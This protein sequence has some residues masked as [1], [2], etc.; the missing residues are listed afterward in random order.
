[1]AMG[2]VIPFARPVSHPTR[3]PETTT[4]PET[5]TGDWLVADSQ[6][7]VEVSA[8]Q[9]EYVN[10]TIE[11]GKKVLNIYRDILCSL[12]RT[13]DF[14]Q[15]CAESCELDNLDLMI[16]QRDRLRREMADILPAS[17]PK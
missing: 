9:L 14:C 11:Q 7:L 4:R 12:Q 2:D 16:E 13:V 3:L 6:A 5:Q 15:R 10:K 8:T 1:M 17:P